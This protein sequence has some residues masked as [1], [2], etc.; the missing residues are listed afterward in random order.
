MNEAFVASHSC[1]VEYIEA[2]KECK[3]LMKSLRSELIN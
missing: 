1:A 3:R 2:K